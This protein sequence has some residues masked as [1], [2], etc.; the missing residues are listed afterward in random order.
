MV[1]ACVAYGDDAAAIGKSE[2]CS[3]AR[4][5]AVDEH[6]PA[7]G[8]LDIQENDTASKVLE[9]IVTRIANGNVEHT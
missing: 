7:A 1:R 9:R 4:E 5:A 8:L 6:K 2:A 3:T